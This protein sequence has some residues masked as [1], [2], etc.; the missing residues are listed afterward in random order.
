MQLS[1]T[2][3]LSFSLDEHISLWRTRRETL[4]WL[5]ILMIQNGTVSLWRLAGYVDTRAQT[6][7]VHRRLERFFKY[8]RPHLPRLIT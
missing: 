6:L 2:K 4:V 7:S 3:S 1:L 8:G 5:V